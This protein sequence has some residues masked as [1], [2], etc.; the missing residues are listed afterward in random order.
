MAAVGT[1]KELSGEAQAVGIDGS[2]RAL[3][4]GDVINEGEVI[5]TIGANSSVKISFNNGKEL[6]LGG[7]EKSL[8]DDSVVSS[9]VV[10]DSD[11]T[12][13]QEAL[14]AGE[15]L[16][17]EATATGQDSPDG[18][19]GI[20]EAYTA[21]RTDGRGDVNSY[22]LG[23]E[24]GVAGNLDGN[25]NDQT[26]QAPEAVD[27]VGVADEDVSFR[28]NILANDVDDGLPNPDGDLDVVSVNGTTPDAFGNI[29]I[30]TEFGVLTLNA[31]TGAYEYLSFNDSLAINE[32][33]IENFEYVVTDGD[34]TDTATLNITLNG[35]NDKPLVADINMGDGHLDRFTFDGVN[36]TFYNNGSNSYGGMATVDNNRIQRINDTTAEVTLQT[37][38][39]SGSEDWDGVKI[40]LYKGEVLTLTSDSGLNDY[41]LGIDDSDHSN[42]T[43]DPVTGAFKWDT[44][45]LTTEA[46]Q[47][48]SVTA[49]SDGWYYIG[50]GA[51]SGDNSPYALYNTTITINGKK[52]IYETRDADS[53]D[54]DTIDDG[55]NVISGTLSATDLDTTDTHLFRL[56]DLEE[57]EIAINIKYIDADN[58]TLDEDSTIQVEIIQSDVD[59]S[60]LDIQ[61]ITLKD[62]DAQDRT[63][64]FDIRGD[65][66]ALGAGE[67]VTLR[68]QYIADDTHGFGEGELPNES[69]VSK[70]AFITVTITGTNDQPVVSD[71]TDTQ[72]EALNGIN[73]FT[74]TLVA[75]DEDVNDTHTYEL[76]SGTIE[77]N[78]GIVTGLT[79]VVNSD[80]TYSVDGNFNALAV[81]ETSTVTFDYIANDGTRDANGES[82][83]SEPAT[84]TLTIVGTNDA[85]I[86]TV[87]DMNA[88]ED[89]QVVIG[90]ASFT[91]VDLSDTHTY[92]V[93]D[94]PEGEG[95]VS[96]DPKT[97][98]YSYNPG[99][100]FQSLAQGEKTEVSFKVTVTDNNGASDTQTVKVTVTGTNDAPNA[101][102]DTITNIADVVVNTYTY[103]NQEGVT[104]SADK[105]DVVN[106]DGSWGIDSTWHDTSKQIDGFGHDETIRF[107]FANAV[108]QA[109]V[110]LTKFNAWGTDDTAHWE[111]F[112]AAG[113][114]IG[115]GD[116]N[117]HGKD[118]S[119][120]VNASEPITR[121]E[122]TAV[123]VASDFLVKSIDTVAFEANPFVIKAGTL[124]ANDTDVDNGAVLT[125]ISATDGAHG[126]VS[127]NSD[128]NIVYTPNTSEITENVV[129]V[130]TY[131]ISD[132]HGATSTQSVA[133]NIN[134]G[135]TLNTYNHLGGHTSISTGEADDAV[136][137]IDDIKENANVDMGAGNDILFVG[138]DIKEHADVKMGEGDDTLILGGEIKGDA[139]VDFGFGEDTLIFN[140]AVDSL[141]L[142]HIDSI[143]IIKIDGANVTDTINI[144]DV[145][146]ATDGNN[147]LSITGNGDIDI[148]AAWGSGTVHGDVTVFEATYGTQTVLLEIDNTINIDII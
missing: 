13:I 136:V 14:L 125:I 60:K 121:I 23:T 26:N 18:T 81:G 79:I 69:S 34:K 83:V 22:N 62:N 40:Y 20:N 129:D 148:E 98:E 3:V 107:D 86:L 67:T 24:R 54:G 141:N 105:G 108:K 106:K 47:S 131:T 10:A 99:S 75:A 97:G 112:N 144:D 71:V 122:I 116:Y 53:T 82:N 49:N 42:G 101:Q 30:T 48:V 65:F 117:E 74:G 96:I 6:A 12:A 41:Y 21:E 46:G 17:D 5:S 37:K 100:D 66:S 31:E 135:D 25:Q 113:V 51:I 4:L 119:F 126:T 85:P 114:K 27:D 16:P 102:S 138:D 132:E 92:S 39:P 88:I 130:I 19:G 7:D 44:L 127:V 55:I 76:V 61:S 118:V 58:A 80:G 38:L 56:I 111:A 147:S 63:S 36:P 87:A 59:V 73:T 128:G 43:S 94:M 35:T 109:T 115:E 32:S 146:G 89:G 139:S 8:M 145:F 133:I 123:G 137:V 15:S 28:G 29:V 84:V 90:N 140:S 103:D 134:T 57:S 68:L 45:A 70:P 52:V 64:D 78:S 1:I 95:S 143:E 120:L 2:T 9:E 93:S 124:L 33:T 110:N 142:S 104:V 72:D 50:T 11:V 77:E 91:D